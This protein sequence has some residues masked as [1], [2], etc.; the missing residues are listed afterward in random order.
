LIATEQ[1]TSNGL[2]FLEMVSP[3]YKGKSFYIDK[4]SVA[5]N[6]LIPA[7]STGALLW[8]KEDLPIIPL[9]SKMGSA[10]GRP[11]GKNKNIERMRNT[12]C[13]M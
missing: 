13:V 2:G 6:N 3:G 10:I 11:Y 7:S 8:A 1:Y 5:D 9:F 4:P 12:K